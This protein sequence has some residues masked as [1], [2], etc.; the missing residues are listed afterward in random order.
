LPSESRSAT[1][2]NNHD[3]TAA[4]LHVRNLIQSAELLNNQ[5][6]DVITL[7]PLS[8][9]SDATKAITNLQHLVHAHMFRYDYIYN[10][11]F[12]DQGGS[13]KTVKDAARDS[14][15]TSAKIRQTV[16]D[17]ITQLDKENSGPS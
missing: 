16:N 17:M 5:L 2:A 10:Y 12:Y 13:Y 8:D 6:E 9:R 7:V 11:I 14:T 15:A 4:E 1:K 3:R